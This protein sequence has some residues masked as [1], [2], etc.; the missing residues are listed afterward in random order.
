[1]TR[2]AVLTESLVIACRALLFDMDGLMVDSEPLWFDVERAFARE[3]GGEWTAEL[4]RGCTGQ[5]MTKTLAVMREQ[6]GFPI[7]AA[8]DTAIIVDTFI[9]RIRELALKPGFIELFQESEALGIPR[10]L[11]SSSPRRLVEATA[12]RFE[13]RERFDAVVSGDD[14]A[15]P[16][17]RPDIFLEAARLLGVPPADCVVLEDSMAGARAGRAAGMRVIAVPESHGDAFLSMADAVVS[18]LHEARTKLALGSLR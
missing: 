17:P 13:L 10:A 11:A 6:F 3:R 12:R 14:V 2:A 1:V 5:G 7:D 18:D 4:A 16:K 15:H 9:G 8:R